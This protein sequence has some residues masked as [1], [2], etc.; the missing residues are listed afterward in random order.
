M[1]EKRALSKNQFI[2][3]DIKIDGYDF[4]QKC[5][6]FYCHLNLKRWGKQ[7][8]MIIFITL[9]SGEKIICN[10]WRENNYFDIGEMPT[11]SRLKVCFVKN[12]KK[13]IVLKKVVL[14]SENE[15]GI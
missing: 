10:V 6:E 3:S 8:N 7:S 13:R 1:E 9:D 11:E 2:M 15:R 14:I 4:P 12:N 5:G